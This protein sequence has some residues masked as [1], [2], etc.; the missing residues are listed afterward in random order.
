MMFELQVETLSLTVVVFAE[1]KRKDVYTTY[2]NFYL[3][4]L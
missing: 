4:A 2:R 1:Q 3:S